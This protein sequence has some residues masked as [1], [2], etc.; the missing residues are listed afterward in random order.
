MFLG[1]AHSD[2]VGIGPSAGVITQVG[3]GGGL[4]GGGLVVGGEVGGGDVVGGLDEGA[5]VPGEALERFGTVVVV[6]G[7]ERG[8][9]ADA[10]GSG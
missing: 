3:L 10:V 1:V 2:T 7:A 8:A 9:E 5:V 4:G 6:V